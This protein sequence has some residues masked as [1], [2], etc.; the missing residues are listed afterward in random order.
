MTNSSLTILLFLG[1]ISSCSPP[2]DDAPIKTDRKSG[3]KDLLLGMSLQAIKRKTALKLIR[4]NPC[5]ATKVYQI[6]SGTYRQVGNITF[7][8]VELTFIHD[9]LYKTVLYK[10]PGRQMTYL[11][12]VYD[13]LLDHP[14]R[15]KI[16]KV[17]GKTQRISEWPGEACYVTIT[18]TEFTD[19]RIEYGSYSGLQKCR[20]AERNC[21]QASQD[22]SKG[23]LIAAVHRR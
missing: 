23:F 8:K 18:E 10:E 4:E 9:Q 1:L 11:S 5:T 21:A 3:H 12:Q 17:V 13:F 15:V 20:E 6:P 19:S 7:H 16:E 2:Q 14:T 22:S